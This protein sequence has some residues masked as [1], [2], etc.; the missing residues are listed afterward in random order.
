MIAPTA[1]AVKIEKKLVPIWMQLNG[2]QLVKKQWVGGS[3][4]VLVTPLLNGYV[5][6]QV[7]VPA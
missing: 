4:C 5:S 6:I 2:F 7:G 3:R 1:D